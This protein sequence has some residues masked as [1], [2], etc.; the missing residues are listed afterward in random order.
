[1]DHS[2]NPFARGYYGFE[3]RRLAVISYD[4]RHP[5]TFL[6]LHPSQAHLPDEKVAYQ[7]CIFNDDFVLITEGKT[8]PAELDA[9]CGGSG[10]VQAVYHSI[11]GRT[12]D[13]GFI[14]VGDSYTLEYAQAVVRNLQFE[15]GF[16]SRAWE[17][18][19]AHITE[20]SG[21]YLCELADIATPSGFL[22]V[23][24]RIPYSPAIGVKLIATPWTDENL[25]HVEGITAEQLRREHLSKGM[26]ED[27]A[28]VLALA[29]QAD[30]RVLVFDA[31]ANELDGLTVFEE[32]DD[33]PS[34][35]T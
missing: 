9:L 8:V 21:R 5:Q 29:G 31:D 12:L 23:A 10:A 6:P 14:H 25:M 17:I 32:E 13:R 20:A 3:I 7:A 24:F 2:S 30:V 28:D 16:Y 18:S 15:T 1:M 27:L 22:F 11:Y 4:E 26:P 33:T 35:D 34:V 19:T